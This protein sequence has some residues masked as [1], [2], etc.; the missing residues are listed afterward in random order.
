L[1]NTLIQQL[2]EAERA[3]DAIELNAVK[4]AREMLKGV[5]EALTARSRQTI[6]DFHQQAQR[7][8]EDERAKTNEE[9]SRL[10]EKRDAEHRALRD[11]ALKNAD[12]A[13]KMIFERIVADGNR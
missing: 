7:M 9:I 10:N 8:L 5:E 2:E 13:G 4:E 11:A 12:A 1:A 3:A 6:R